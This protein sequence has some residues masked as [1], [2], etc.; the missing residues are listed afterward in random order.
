MTE[1][2]IWCRIE[3]TICPVLKALAKIWEA[4]NIEENRERLWQH[5][6][7]LQQESQISHRFAL[8]QQKVPIR[9][10]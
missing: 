5:Q 4:A 10:T 9:D 8:G 7:A 1:L 2:P 3:V 6:N